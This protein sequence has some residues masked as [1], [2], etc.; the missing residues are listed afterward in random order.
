[1]GMRGKGPHGFVPSY[2]LEC[3]R[4]CRK[5]SNMTQ[6]QMTPEAMQAV[7]DVLQQSMAG[8]TRELDGGCHDI[9][10]AR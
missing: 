3:Y 4:A 8:S 7:K 6:P 5:K 2:K 10:G 9:A 1:M